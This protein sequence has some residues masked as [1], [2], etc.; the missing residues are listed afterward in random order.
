MRWKSETIDER[1]KRLETWRPWFAWRPVVVD[2]ERVW[3]EWIFRRTKMHYAGL[4]EY[5]YE[6]EFADAMSILRKQ[7]AMKDYDG[8]E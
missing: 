6:V 7:E 1:R 3:L 2:N 4:G 8:L 5:S